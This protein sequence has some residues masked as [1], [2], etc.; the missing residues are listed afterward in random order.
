M[1]TLHF[2]KS[3]SRSPLRLGFSLVALTLACFALPMET[4]ADCGETGDIQFTVTLLK[5][6]KTRGN[7]NRCLFVKGPPLNTRISS[8]VTLGDLTVGQPCTFYAAKETFFSP[9]GFWDVI[10]Y[11][12]C[13]PLG[14]IPELAIRK[15]VK[16]ERPTNRVD[17]TLEETPSGRVTIGFSAGGNKGAAASGEIATGGLN[18]LEQS[19]ASFLR[20]VSVKAW[21]GDSQDPSGRPDSDMFSFV[22]NAG[23]TVRLRL[24]PD[25]QGGNNRGHATLRFVGPPARQVTGVLTAEH[26]NTFNFPVE[27]DSTRRYDIVVEQAEGSGTERYRGG[28]ILTVESSLGNIERLVPNDSVEK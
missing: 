28:Y 8:G 9:Y 18:T 27:L 10:L 4:R 25:N 26:P 6:L 7:M 3:I 19:Q 14:Y 22:G 13:I 23:D 24:E 15:F 21:L 17:I 5:P 16:I 12:T 2:K 20:E 1:T 11:P